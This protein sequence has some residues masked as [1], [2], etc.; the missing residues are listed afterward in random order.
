VRADFTESSQTVSGTLLA[1]IAWESERAPGVPRHGRRVFQVRAPW[2]LAPQRLGTRAVVAE[3]LV[4]EAER[5][6]KAVRLL[7]RSAGDGD[8]AAAKALIP[9]LSQA[10]GMPT[11]RVEHRVPSSLDELEQMSTEELE[12]LVAEGRAERLQGLRAVPEPSDW[13]R[14]DPSL[15]EVDGDISG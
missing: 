7:C 11:E 2:G 13:R 8:L 9:W 15:G 3:A 14:R 12:R 4:A 6:D 5:V 10:L 1:S